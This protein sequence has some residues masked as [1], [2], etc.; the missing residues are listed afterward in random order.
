MFRLNSSQASY[1]NNQFG[2][3]LV[4]RQS[5]HGFLQALFDTQFTRRNEF[6]PEG[7]YYS[8]V[9]TLSGKPEKI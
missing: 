3:T 2:L 8:L 5:M 4:P 1:V 7:T 9:F 6:R